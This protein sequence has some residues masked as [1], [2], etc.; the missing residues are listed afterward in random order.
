MRQHI[1]ELQPWGSEQNGEHDMNSSCLPAS[2]ECEWR[3]N[4]EIGCP[5]VV[6][7]Q[8]TT[9]LGPL[10]SSASH[11][12]YYIYWFYPFSFIKPPLTSQPHTYF[13]QNDFPPLNY[14][15]SFKLDQLTY[16]SWTSDQELKILAGRQKNRISRIMR[17]NSL[18]YNNTKLYGPLK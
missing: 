12:H 4:A 14:S 7:C 3:V 10:P 17:N 18:A 16:G 8:L 9:F 5:W 6:T 1:K 13:S 11:V 15:Y 2:M